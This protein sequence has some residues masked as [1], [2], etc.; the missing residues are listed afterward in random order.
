MRGSVVHVNA[1]ELWVGKGPEAPRRG[2]PATRP[3]MAGQ[4]SLWAAAA[5]AVDAATKPVP[6]H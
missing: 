4:H 3:G 2:T 6:G 5:V 1:A